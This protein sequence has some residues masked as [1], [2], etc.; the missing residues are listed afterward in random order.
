MKQLLD[1]G[2][3]DARIFL[4]KRSAWLWLFAAPLA[5][6][7]FLGLVNQGYG[8]PGNWRPPVLITNKDTNFLGRLFLEEL[9]AQGMRRVDS[10]HRDSAESVISIPADF[11][12][13]A[14]RGEP[15]KIS[16]SERDGSGEADATLIELRITRAL[17]AMNG[18]ILEVGVA[19][20][21]L[22][23]AMARPNPVS[24]N[25]HFAGL[26]PVPTGFNFSLPGNLVMYLMLD[27]LAFGGMS[28]ATMRSDGIIRRFMANPVTRNEIIMGKIYGLMLLGAVQIV[29]L[30]AVGKFALGVNLGANLPAVTLTL[31]I[32]A[33]V[34][35][36]FGVL[37]GSL[38]SA[39][40]R[41]TGICVLIAVLLAALGGCWWPLEVAP[42]A[43]KT[44]AL[45]T[46]TGWALQALH[47]LISFGSGFGAVLIPI[48]VLAAFG[49]AANLLAV[50]FFRS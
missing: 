40:D 41:V 12:E 9:D 50:R 11:T 5:F 46:P 45:F 6:T 47:R 28:V 39:E 8:D 7:Y 49:V 26:K 23:Q 14:I 29:F 32:F 21:K 10:A 25:A 36:S 42:A 4:R 16:L 22:R 38:V 17:I 27:L 34:G 35:S 15:V 48:A 37:V 18:H 43:F 19:E 30:L 31:L 3:T 20:D 24:L 33:W 2:Q 13:K 44:I 1:I